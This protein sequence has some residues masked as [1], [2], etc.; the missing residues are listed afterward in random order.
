VE[1]IPTSWVGTGPQP[2]YRDGVLHHDET[3]YGVRRG[4][5]NRGFRELT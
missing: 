2:V 3:R 4:E 5:T 1:D